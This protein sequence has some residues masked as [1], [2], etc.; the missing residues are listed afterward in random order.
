MAQ[1]CPPRPL[2]C[3]H[4]DRSSQK[5][6]HHPPGK[7]WFK[8]IAVPPVSFSIL[9]IDR[10]LLLCYLICGELSVALAAELSIICLFKKTMKIVNTLRLRQ[11]RFDRCRGWGC[12]RPPLH[13]AGD[14]ACGTPQHF[15]LGGGEVLSRCASRR[16]W[17]GV[18]GA[19]FLLDRGA[20]SIAGAEG[21][22]LEGTGYGGRRQRLWTR[23]GPFSRIT[24]AT[25]PTGGTLRSRGGP[26][27][28][29]ASAGA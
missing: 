13:D 20:V 16:Q 10:L 27:R 8:C 29:C 7:H 17:C 21:G 14:S 9:H 6:H 3:V 28:R 26:L 5:S 12:S 4:I 22:P 11:M 2:E 18:R 25:S 19:F 15:F 24:S 23:V 1:W